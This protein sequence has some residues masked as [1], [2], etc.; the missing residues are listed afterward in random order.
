MNTA[1]PCALV[2]D[3]EPDIC[4]LLAITLERMGIKADTCGDV[5]AA[6]T[7]LKSNDYQIC[8]TDMRLP[9]ADGLDLVQ[10][11][12]SKGLNTPVA[13]ITAHGNVETASTGPE[14]GRFRFYLQAGR[15]AGP[16]K[17]RRKRA[18]AWCHA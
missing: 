3:D 2:V 16:E 5:A 4:E 1:K 15:P 11:M 17:S 13:V 14:A 8:L 12:Q 7:R 10:W 18:A 9:D 6:K